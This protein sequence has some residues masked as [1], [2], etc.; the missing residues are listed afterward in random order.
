MGVIADRARNGAALPLAAGEFR[1]AALQ[2]MTDPEKFHGF[3]EL[4][5]PARIFRALEAEAEIVLDVQMREKARLLKNVAERAAVGGKED[6]LFVV[7]PRFV[8]D[9]DPALG[10]FQPRDA[11]KKRG[12][13]AARRS[14]EHGD[15]LFRERGLGLESKARRTGEA[16]R[17]AVFHR[18]LLPAPCRSK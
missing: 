8:G 18:P 11:A 13:S 9:D 2:K 4:F 12:L 1:D 5:A 16:N 10:V 3:G 15:A 17:Y 6:S 14:E 7:L